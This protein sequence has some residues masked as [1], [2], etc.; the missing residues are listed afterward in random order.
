MENIKPCGTVW[1]HT[2]CAKS[3][4]LRISNVSRPHRGRPLAATCENALP[5]FSGGHVVAG[6]NPVSPTLSARPCQPDLVSP[7]LSARPCQP[8][9]CQP[10]PCQPDPCQPD[11]RRVLE[12]QKYTA[13]HNRKRLS[14]INQD[15]V[16]GDP[17]ADVRRDR[18][19]G[20]TVLGSRAGPR[21]LPAPTSRRHRAWRSSSTG[22]VP[23]SARSD[24]WR[25][26][27]S[28]CPCPGR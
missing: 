4:G 7:T 25:P 13:D 14:I 11:Q 26:Q 8:D 3:S 17:A 1:D 10:D 20:T 19:T 9:P 16:D 21:R 12:L 18:P 24:A 6:S 28:R 27:L 2:L 5:Q 23:R 15:A 22:A